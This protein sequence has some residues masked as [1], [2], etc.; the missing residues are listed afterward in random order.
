MRPSPSLEAEVECA[1]TPYL[2]F[3]KWCVALELC[4]AARSVHAPDNVPDVIVHVLA[5]PHL[6]SIF[7]L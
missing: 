6:A 5:Q 4:C 2:R 1:S 7:S 3:F